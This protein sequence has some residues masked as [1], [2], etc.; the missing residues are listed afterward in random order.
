MAAEAEGG[1]KCKQTNK[2]RKKLK[3]IGEDDMKTEGIFSNINY[4]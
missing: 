2:W 1:R 3:N 4:F